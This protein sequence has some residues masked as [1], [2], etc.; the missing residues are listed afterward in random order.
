MGPAIGQ[1]GLNLMAFCKDFN[2]RTADFVPDTP[3]KCYITA[4][5]DK[6]YDMRV[7]MPQVM[8]AS[9]RIVGTASRSLCEPQSRKLSCLQTSWYIKKAAG[10]QSGAKQ[11]GKEAS[12]GPKWYSAPRYTPPRVAGAL[13]LSLRDCMQF[14][15]VLTRKHIYEIALA[16]SADFANKDNLQG[17]CRSILS[18]CHTMGIDVVADED[19]A[20]AK[21]PQCQP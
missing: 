10:V 14:V 19:A 16:K 17:I 4:Y 11:P 21:Y 12:W 2:A 13:Q 5:T 1:A 8:V 18:Q 15:G 20:R 7:M 3:M 6:S 9:T